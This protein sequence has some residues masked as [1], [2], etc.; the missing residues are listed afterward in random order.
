M[1]VVSMSSV[2][3]GGGGA[4]A[5]AAAAFIAYCNLPPSWLLPAEKATLDWL[6]PAPLEQL[7][8]V[9]RVIRGEDMW[10]ERGAVIMAIRRPG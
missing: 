8:S 3:W 2:L 4:V 9:S 7:G 6:S 10:R 1:S 5:A